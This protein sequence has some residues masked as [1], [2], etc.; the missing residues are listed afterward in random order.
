MSVA[1]EDPWAHILNKA[2]EE[3]QRHETILCN[4]GATTLLLLLLLW[5]FVRR[6]RTTASFVVAW[7]CW[8]AWQVERGHSAW[9]QVV[10]HAQNAATKT[11]DAIRAVVE[12][13]AAWVAFF[14]PAL[15]DLCL[16]AVN[17]WIHR[18]SSL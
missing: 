6:P 2:F 16:V 3:L 17:R 5:N 9:Q 11:S 4:I 10:K 7:L 14:V 12:M 15:D 13:L 8:F 1:T 18:P